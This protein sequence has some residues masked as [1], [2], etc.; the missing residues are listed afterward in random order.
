MVMDRDQM[1]GLVQRHADLETKLDLDGVMST[2]V[3]HPIYEFYPIRLKLEGKENVREFYRD[4]FLSFFPMIASHV[5]ISETW[6]SDA[7]FLEYDL[8]LKDHSEKTYR[9]MV[10]LNA[11][12]SLL[13]GEKFFVDDELVKFMCGNSFSKLTGI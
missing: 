2:L 12:N 1:R 11:K 9:I 10:V 3:D 6:L 4:H 8:K 5:V 7:A 13:I